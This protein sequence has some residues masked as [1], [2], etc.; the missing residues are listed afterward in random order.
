VK[1]IPTE[2]DGVF[3]IETEVFRDERG[4]LI[5]AYAADQWR[6]L[7]LGDCFVQD[8]VSHSARGTVRGMHYQIEPHGMGKLVW[9]LH[10]AIFDVAVDIRR[11]S[12]TFGNWIGRT[13]E[14]DAGKAMW[15]PEGFAHG[16]MALE[17]ETI[18]Y[19]KCTAPYTPHAE[20]VFAYNDPEVAVHWPAA[21]E[22]V[23]ERDAAAPPLAKAETNFVY[24]D[25]QQP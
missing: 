7:G 22:H 9:P 3:V 11:G 8:N 5:V 24:K 12:A 2:L 6:A 16:F 13:L 15:L 1:A 18:V 21:P 23:S 14:A 20:R 10:G 4:Y 25:K 19:Y 17:P